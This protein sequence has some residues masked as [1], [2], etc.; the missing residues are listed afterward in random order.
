MR[1]ETCKWWDNSRTSTMLSDTGTCRA[2]PPRADDRN[3]L[4]VWPF[5]EDNDWCAAHT[6]EELES[7]HA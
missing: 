6:P 4:A 7:K 2:L 5:T 3:G 1:C